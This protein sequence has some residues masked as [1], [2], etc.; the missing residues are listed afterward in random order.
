MH[1]EARD[2]AR[3]STLY[4]NLTRHTERENTGDLFLC[5]ALLTR[6]GLNKVVGEGMNG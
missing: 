3:Y 1:I 5:S 2:G 4:L 6:Q